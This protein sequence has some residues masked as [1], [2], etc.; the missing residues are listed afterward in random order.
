MELQERIEIQV[1]QRYIA[2]LAGL[3][4]TRVLDLANEK[5]NVCGHP[6]LAQF[7]FENNIVNLHQL[8]ISQKN[9]IY[10]LGRI[11]IKTLHHSCHQGPLQSIVQYRLDINV[12]QM[13]AGA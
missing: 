2:S 13:M 8:S 4:A 12:K 6:G 5:R 1:C 10:S 9:L 11:V 7:Y 3:E